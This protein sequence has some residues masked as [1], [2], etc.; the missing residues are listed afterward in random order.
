[1]YSWCLPWLHFLANYPIFNVDYR[2]VCCRR[3]GR[4]SFV[5]KFQRIF[6]CDHGPWMGALIFS[7][8]LHFRC[9]NFKMISGNTLIPPT[10]TNKLLLLWFVICLC[11]ITYYFFLSMSFYRNNCKIVNCLCANTNQFLLG[12]WFCL[13]GFLFSVSKIADCVYRNCNERNLQF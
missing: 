9:L 7:L 10:S 3:K 4:P 1:M 12:L 2:K 8:L 11:V 13:T 6:T 5:L